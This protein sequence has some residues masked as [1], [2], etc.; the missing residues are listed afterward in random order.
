ME[1]SKAL[2]G[3]GSAFSVESLAGMFEQPALECSLL[4]RHWG[5]CQE[6]DSKKC[7]GPSLLEICRAIKA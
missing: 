2:Q 7:Q 4:A 6:G 3:D 5:S 1:K